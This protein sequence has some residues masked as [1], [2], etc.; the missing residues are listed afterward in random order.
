MAMFDS[1]AVDPLLI[2]DT[3][4]LED[5]TL[6]RVLLMDDRRYPWIVLVPKRPNITELH[7]MSAS[8]LALLID[9][10]AT[11]AKVMANFGDKVN[12]GMLGNIVQ[13]LHVHVVARRYYDEAW[14]QPVWGSGE[15][16]PYDQA[17]R[18]IM[19]ARIMR[20]F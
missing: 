12:I 3:A 20:D 19:V 16:E 10:I 18:A 9:E 5:W 13:Q 6:C 4:F 1:F 8:D 15:R 14:P 2:K 7:Q 11:A 17:A